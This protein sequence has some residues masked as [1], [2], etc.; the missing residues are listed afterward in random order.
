LSESIGDKVAARAAFAPD[1]PLIG[2]AVI[3]AGSDSDM[4][5]FSLGHLSR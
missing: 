4:S 3:H 1:A 5:P 2:R